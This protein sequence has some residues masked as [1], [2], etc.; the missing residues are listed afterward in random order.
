MKARAIVVALM[1]LASPVRADVE[2]CPPALLAR[3]PSPGARARVF[4]DSA[5]V[6]A[7]AGMEQVATLGYGT[8]VQVVSCLNEDGSEA[9]DWLARHFPSV[10]A[11]ALYDA[12]CEEIGRAH[13]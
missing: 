11:T 9:S 3:V 2:E 5:Q 7:R 8:E 4:V 12:W 6:R 1:L 10:G 13:V